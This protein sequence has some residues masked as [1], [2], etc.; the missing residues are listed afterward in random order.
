MVIDMLSRYVASGLWGECI[1]RDQTDGSVED[2]RM[3]MGPAADRLTTATRG[4]NRVELL[5]VGVV[6]WIGRGR[7][8]FQNSIAGL[9][10]AESRQEPA[11]RAK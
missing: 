6:G 7:P 5:E 11:G 10:A 3:A 9:S 1:Y 4:E 2:E 8:A